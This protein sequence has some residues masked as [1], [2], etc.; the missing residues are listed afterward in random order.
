LQWQAGLDFICE[1]T[2]YELR[3][4]QKEALKKLPYKDDDVVLVAMTGEE[5]RPHWAAKLRLESYV[6]LIEKSEQIK[7]FSVPPRQDA[8]YGHS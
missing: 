2:R 3:A 1:K 4:G 5:L 7:G 6:Y 8:V